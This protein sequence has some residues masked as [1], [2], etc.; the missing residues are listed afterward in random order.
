MLEGAFAH[1][2]MLPHCTSWHRHDGACP[3]MAALGLRDTIIISIAE[4]T[5]RH[6]LRSRN[7]DCVSEPQCSH[8]RT[9]PIMPSVQR[10]V[11]ICLPHRSLAAQ[12]CLYRLCMTIMRILP[13]AL[14]LTC[15]AAN[16][17]RTYETD[18][19]NLDTMASS[20]HLLTRRL[21]FTGTSLPCWARLWPVVPCKAA[22]ELSL[23][24]P[25][26]SSCL[27]KGSVFGSSELIWDDHA[28]AAV[29]RGYVAT[30]SF[31]PGAGG[32][33]PLMTW[34]QIDGTPLRLDADDDIHV[35]VPTAGPQ[36]KVPDAAKRDELGR[37]MAQRARHSLQRK[38]QA[39]MRT[40][41][42]SPLSTPGAFGKSAAQTPMSPAARRLASSLH[43]RCAPEL[44]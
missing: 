44:L 10:P 42:H 27:D 13:P 35:E 33:S 24:V 15:C 21:P 39:R 7:D 29:N 2:L 43:G 23:E 16:E 28:G 18:A 34:G 32:E 3:V 14:A 6:N 5:T 41:L 20:N 19:C 30:P 1:C 17:L 4:D 11:S 25:E 36:F 22:V 12:C 8:H 31:T 37:D 26:K 40:P 38:I 9:G